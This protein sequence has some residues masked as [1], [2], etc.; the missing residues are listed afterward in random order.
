VGEALLRRQ[1]VTCLARWS[2]LK[3]HD[4]ARRQAAR[5]LRRATG[6]DFDLIRIRLFELT[7]CMDPMT[8]ECLDA[9]PLRR[10]VSG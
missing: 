9:K 8:C 1:A 2:R 3:R 5:Q 7:W 10:M 6:D 4:I